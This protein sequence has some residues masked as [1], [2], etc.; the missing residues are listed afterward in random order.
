MLT[1]VS[2]RYYTH[3]LNQKN[4]YKSIAFSIISLLG[5]FTITS[6]VAQG[7][8]N[9]KLKANALRHVVLLKFNESSTRE[10]IAKVETAFKDLAK[11]LKMVKDFEWGINN[12]PENLNQGLTHCFILTFQSEKD[13]DDYSVHPEHEKFVDVLKLH[14]EK[15]TVVDF[16]VKK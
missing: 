9:E 12:S 4:M 1:G 3:Y 2:A 11:K 13:R 14:M 10:D 16:W 8:Q 6:A 7:K 5:I 15:A